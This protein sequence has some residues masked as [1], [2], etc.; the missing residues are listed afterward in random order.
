MPSCDLYVLLAFMNSSVSLA[1]LQF[2]SPTLNYEAGHM[3]KLPCSEEMFKGDKI[4]VEQSQVC[5]TAAKADWN[6]SETSWGFRKH[7][8]V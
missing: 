7:F 5:V 2:L 4:I 6:A 8:L 1:M 3:A